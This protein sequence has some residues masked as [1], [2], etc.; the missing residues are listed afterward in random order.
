MRSLCASKAGCVHAAPPSSRPAG[1]SP[2]AGPP[3]LSPGTLGPL[4]FSL[5][6]TT[7]HSL[8]SEA[9]V[10]WGAQAGTRGSAELSKARGQRGPRT[11][12]SFLSLN[13]ERATTAAILADLKHQDFFRK[14]LALAQENGVPALG[15]GRADRSPRPL[16]PHRQDSPRHLRPSLTTHPPPRPVL[17]PTLLLTRCPG[18]LLGPHRRPPG[19]RRPGG[20]RRQAWQLHGHLPSF[21]HVWGSRSVPVGAQL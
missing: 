13:W 5:P 1:L 16:M 10:G 9:A 8:G 7:L 6:S 3:K 19:H 2:A 11:P 21:G 20:R 4:R 12:L 15:R 18:G 17:G 14:I